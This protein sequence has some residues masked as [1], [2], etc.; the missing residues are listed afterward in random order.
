M[1]TKNEELVSA[2]YPGARSEKYKTNG[3]ET[4]YL[5]VCGVGATKK[6]LGDGTTLSKAWKDAK[7]N[8][9]DLY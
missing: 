4:Y 6:R 3:G 7:D 1:K 9:I 5:I 2:K 8:Y